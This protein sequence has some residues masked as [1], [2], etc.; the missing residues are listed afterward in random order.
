M[1]NFKDLSRDD[2]L[3]YYK[4]TIIYST[5]DKKC[6]VVLDV[7]AH[8]EHFLAEDLKGTRFTIPME[9]VRELPFFEV[10]KNME[11]SCAF[12]SRNPVRQYKKGI[13]HTNTKISHIGN[14]FLPNVELNKNITAFFED[15]KY[16]TYQEAYE[17]IKK[18]ER[19]S[20]AFS[21]KF[22]LVLSYFDTK[23]YVVHLDF[24]V[25]EAFEKQAVIRESVFYLKEE[26][27]QYISVGVLDEAK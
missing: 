5:K 10:L 15:E 21:P 13:N 16:P 19:V 20:V 6:G 9:H 25:G 24:V 27:S 26:L 22:G 7:S 14:Q 18:G 1:I 17:L 23:I 8:Y 11:Y 4:D 12:I 3:M 2:V